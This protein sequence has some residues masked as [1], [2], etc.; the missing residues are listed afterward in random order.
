MEQK[1]RE[2][3]Q[4]PRFGVSLR[5]DVS[6][7]AEDED[8]LFPQARLEGRTRDV[9]ESGIGVLLS[10]IYIGFACVVDEGRALR[11]ALSLPS[12]SVEMHATPAHYVRLDERGEQTSYLV[13]L[14]ITEM[15]DDDRAHY[16]EY[17]STLDK[18]QQV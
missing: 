16:I 9:S 6:L 3:R 14:R 5:C 8:L 18:S 7:P 11:L 2:R 13:G 15:S 12:G 17:L 4:S 1:G 10:S